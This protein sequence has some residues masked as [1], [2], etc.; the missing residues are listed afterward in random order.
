MTT[1]YD[2][3]SYYD[4]LFGWDRTGEAR[5]YDRMIEIADVGRDEPVLEVACGTGQIAI[6]LALLGRSV[7]GLDSSRDMLD[8]LGLRAS[9]EGVTV[10]TVCADMTTFADGTSF[11]AAYNP[12]NSFRL[13][14]SDADAGSHLDA[15]AKSLRPGGVYVLDMDFS[16]RLDDVPVTTDEEWEMTRDGVIVKA[17]DD[18]IYVDDHGTRLEIP[19]G[20]EGHL[21]NYTTAAFADLVESVRPLAIESWHPETGREGDEETSVFDPEQPL[22]VCSTGR[23]MVVLRRA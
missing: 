1:I 11:G 18:A 14:Q 8:F 12:M 2:Y 4:I 16:D 7:T 17:T 10:R 9:A 23:G 3:P 22:D 20:A 19:W 13:L 5:F 15:I 6:H 21:R